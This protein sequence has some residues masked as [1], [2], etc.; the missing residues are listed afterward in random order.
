ML[1]S[2]VVKLNSPL[3]CKMEHTL[4]LFCCNL[5][6]LWL[7]QPGICVASM[8]WQ[9]RN[10]V[11]RRCIE[12]CFPPHF[13]TCEQTRGSRPA[14]DGLRAFSSGPHAFA[15]QVIVRTCLTW[16]QVCAS[17][18]GWY[19]TWLDELHGATPEGQSTRG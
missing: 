13:L 14:V 17:A 11:Y 18:M 19:T 8:Q 6:V 1:H 3:S 7:K 4:A 12:N 2:T 10:V 9:R 16:T 5:F 15:V